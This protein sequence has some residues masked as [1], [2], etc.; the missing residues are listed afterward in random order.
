VTALSQL[1]ADSRGDLNIDAQVAK[2]RDAGHRINRATVYKALRGEHAKNPPDE[3]LKALAYVFGL[4]V[5]KVREAA[6]RPP[7]EL[8]PWEPTAEAGQLS[9]DQRD[10]LNNLIKTIVRG[11]VAHG[12]ATP[13]K[14]APASRA[15][16]EQD[17]AN[18]AGSSLADRYRDAK[19]ADT[20]P[21]PEERKR[22]G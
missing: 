2:A 7:G 18:E 11:G 19:K 16:T 3:M 10:A 5:R 20:R 9:Q 1:L 17:R 6:D 8:G 15:E 13:A 12:N 4:D 21:S 22:H 14:R